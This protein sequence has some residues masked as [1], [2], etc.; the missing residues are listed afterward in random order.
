MMSTVRARLAAAATPLALATLLAPAAPAGA[1]RRPP[2]EPGRYLVQGEPLLAGA[3]APRIDALDVGATIALGDACPA[4]R[5]ARMKANRK[6]ATVVRAAWRR[7]EGLRGRVR[8][9]GRIVEGCTTL[10]GKVRARGFRRRFVAARSRCGDGV[11][12]PAAGERCDGTLLGGATC[13]SLGHGGN[14]LGC[15]ADCTGYDTRGCTA[16]CGDGSKRAPGEC[17]PQILID[18]PAHGLFTREPAV[19][20]SGRVRDVTPEDARLLVNGVPVAIGPDLAF[21]TRVDLVPA[22]VFNPIL[23]TLTRPRD[24]RSAAAR[25]VVIAGDSLAEGSWSPGGVAIRLEDRGLDRIE[26]ALPGLLDVDLGALVPPGFPVVDEFCYLEFLGCVGAVDVRVSGNPRPRVGGFSIDLDARAARV[27]SHL[28]LR[29]VFVR[30]DVDDARGVPFACRVDVA[31]DTVDVRGEYALE[32]HPTLP[33]RIDVQQL[34]R[35]SAAVSDLRVTT[36]CAGPLSGAL[37]ALLRAVR[38]QMTDLLVSKLEDALNAP[39]PRGDPP[40][41]AALEEALAGIDLTGALGGGLGV[42]LDARYAA[43]AEDPAGITLAL[44]VRAAATAPDARAPDLAASYHVDEA[45]PVFAST[46]PV[47]GEPFG[48]GLGLS[49]SAVNQVIR[50]AVESGLLG[51]EL[52]AVDLG[53]G[54]LSITAGLLAGVIPALGALPAETPLTL[55]IAPTLAPIVTGRPGPAGEFAEL[56]VS[57][58]TAELVETGAAPGGGDAVWLGLAVDA[59]LGLD[60]HFDAQGRFGFGV[61]VPAPGEISLVPVRNPLGADLTP[62]ERLLPTLFGGALQAVGGGLGSIPLPRFEGLALRGVEV[63]RQGTYLALFVELVE[64]R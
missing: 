18:T 46:T 6:G 4:R 38:E 26:G 30:L 62:L 53:E 50:A 17:D 10:R 42:V 24:G 12:D 43:V 52:A 29:D 44:D 54:P 21:S 2:C 1:A 32:P 59:V 48:L 23:V 60:L 25:V 28:R 19:V 55:R 5:P 8:L 20:V 27:A 41:A 33:G 7:C 61:S 36:D 11:L 37:D 22:D 35:A 15:L 13:T 57:H 9:A 49:T 56:L 34:G 45:F 58:L 3:A 47:R 63:S 51:L 64:P 16:T 40:V 31:A 39:D 14:A